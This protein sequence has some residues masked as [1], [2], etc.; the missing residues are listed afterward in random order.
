MPYSDPAKKAEYNRIYYQNRKLRINAE[1]IAKNLKDNNQRCIRESTLM[2]YTEEYDD[3][4]LTFLIDLVEKCKD[5]RARLYELPKP[6]PI[7][8]AQA[9]IPV[10]SIPFVQ[11]LPITKTFKKNNNNDTFTIDEAKLV[12]HANRTKDDGTS[13]TTYTSKLNAIM[14][15]F[16]LSKV[17][18][19]FSD[20]YKNS[21]EK[22]IETFSGYA[23]PS[24]YIVR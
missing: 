21:Y 23:N 13:E 6:V 24:Q 9:P 1:K 4:Q 8:E 17:D 10:P 15:K 5:E 18:G 14:T 19:I 3:N 7:V 20:V 11:R 16:N 12:I 2:K 22:I